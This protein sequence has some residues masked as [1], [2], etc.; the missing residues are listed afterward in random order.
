[1]KILVDTN[2]LIDFFARREPF[3]ADSV[4]IFELCQQEIVEGCIAAFSVVNMAYI[5]R[6]NFS[7]DELKK[8]F[9]RL[10]KLFQVEPIDIEKILR[11]IDDNTFKDFEDCLQMQCAITFNADFIVTR[12]VDDFKSS[13]IPAITPADFCKIFENVEEI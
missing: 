1:M 5:L 12:N 4:K 7:L 8:I 13:C 10:C 3:L 11:A 6:K 9:L 2:V